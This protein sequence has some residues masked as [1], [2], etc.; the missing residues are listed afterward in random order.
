MF[1]VLLNYVVNISDYVASTAG[2]L[3]NDKLESG[4]EQV[5]T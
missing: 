4:K 3:L 5:V 1:H 2:L